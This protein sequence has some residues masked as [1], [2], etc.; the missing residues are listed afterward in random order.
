M[1]S[2]IKSQPFEMTMKD[3]IKVGNLKDTTISL[4]MQ[5][6]K[7][8]HAEDNSV[9]INQTLLTFNMNFEARVNFTM[10]DTVFFLFG[11]DVKISEVKLTQDKINLNKTDNL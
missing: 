7:C 6:D 3:G 9:S 2:D 8:A 4:G 5:F 1:V 10:Q 11:K